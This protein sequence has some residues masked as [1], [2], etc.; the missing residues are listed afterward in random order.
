MNRSVLITFSFLLFGS[1]FGCDVID[2][3]QN[4][5]PDVVNPPERKIPHSNKFD[6]ADCPLSFDER[7]RNP[8]LGDSGIE[9]PEHVLDPSKNIDRNGLRRAAL[10]EYCAAI[11]RPF[12]D[13][14]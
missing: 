8:G 1:L 3:D 10:E 11:D 9:T 4:S 12:S 13:R 6:P 2:D 14:G 7:L 5:N